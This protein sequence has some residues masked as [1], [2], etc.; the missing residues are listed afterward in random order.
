[1]KIYF[2]I[3]LILGVALHA[4]PQPVSDCSCAHQTVEESYQKSEAVFLGRVVKT[5][6]RFEK[7]VETPLMQ[8]A[9]EYIVGTFEVRKAWKGNLDSFVEVRTSKSGCGIRF[10]IADV[11]LVFAAK[12]NNQLITGLCQLTKD[13]RLA[14]EDVETL[15]NK[16]PGSHR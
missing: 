16:Y 8:Y 15:N 12:A 4:D 10:I 5:E 1:M 9:S 7:E 6:I 13:E 11:Y 3:L 2:Q 14:K